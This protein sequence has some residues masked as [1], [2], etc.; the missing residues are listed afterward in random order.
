MTESIV[1]E[2]DPIAFVTCGEADLRTGA[3]YLPNQATQLHP[4]SQPRRQGAVG[5]DAEHR[6][7][8][9]RPDGGGRSGAGGDLRPAR[10]PAAR[11]GAASERTSGQG[12]SGRGAEADADSTPRGHRSK[13]TSA[14][15]YGRPG[16]EWVAQPRFRKRHRDRSRTWKHRRRGARDEPAGEHPLTLSGGRKWWWEVA[17]PG[18]WGDPGT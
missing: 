17:E 15:D 14:P 2:A 12:S 5:T 16:F 1:E 7:C 8:P 10:L 3:V 6:L 4:A 18:T 11:T 13:P 9:S